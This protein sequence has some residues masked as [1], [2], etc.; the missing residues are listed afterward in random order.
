MSLILITGGARCGK[1]AVAQR[2]V[3]ECAQ[4][5]TVV[6]FGQAG[7][8]HEMAARIARHKA[9]RPAGFVTVEARDSV[10]WTARVSDGVM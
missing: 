10:E 5:V 8:D 4:D 2:L 9:D 1:S 7:E 3:Q 6:V